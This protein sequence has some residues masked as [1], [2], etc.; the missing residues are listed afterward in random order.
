MASYE[1]PRLLVGPCEG[2]GCLPRLVARMAALPHSGNAKVPVAASGGLLVSS[3][4][5]GE[6][7]GLLKRVSQAAV[8]CRRRDPV[9]LLGAKITEAESQAPD[10]R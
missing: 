6:W 4:L 3:V 5:G 8:R 1:A 2:H 10:A 9:L 7:L